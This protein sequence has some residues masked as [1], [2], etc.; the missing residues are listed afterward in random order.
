MANGNITTASEMKA[1]VGKIGDIPVG[2]M[3]VTVKIVDARERWGRIDVLVTP[4]KGSGQQ[5]KS[6]DTLINVRK[7]R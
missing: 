6:L 5:W 7:G 2:E 4:L 3:R 1:A